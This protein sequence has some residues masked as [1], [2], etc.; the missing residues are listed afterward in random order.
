MHLGESTRKKLYGY[1]FETKEIGTS[2][3][4]SGLSNFSLTGIK[5]THG[6][7]KNIFRH[8]FL[9]HVAFGFI[10]KNVKENFAPF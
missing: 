10:E 2:Q 7:V 3:V 5:M 9:V 1:T 4:F 6:G 8:S